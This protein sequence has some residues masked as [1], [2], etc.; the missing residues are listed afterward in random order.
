R[1][2]ACAR[3]SGETEKPMGTDIFS[4]GIRVHLRLDG[5]S[6]SHAG[7]ESG[8]ALGLTRWFKGK[9]WRQALDTLPL[10]FSICSVAQR[11]AAVT[12]VERAAAIGP[13]PHRQSLRELVLDAETAREHLFR[14]FT[15]WSAVLGRQP[16]PKALSSV[17]RLVPEVLASM[18]ADS[19]L[20]LPGTAT[21][22]PDAARL[23]AALN[24]LDSLLREQ[25]LGVDPGNWY[26]MSTVEEFRRW[27]DGSEGLAAQFLRLLDDRHWAE[28]PIPPCEPLPLLD[29]DFLTAALAGD[30]SATFV[31]RP[32]V[33]GR[34]CETGAYVRERHHPLVRAV[35]AHRGTGILMR[36]VARFLELAALPTRMRQRLVELGGLEPATEVR[37][38]GITGVGIGQAEAAR[39]RLVH[40]VVLQDEHVVDYQIVAPTEWNFHPRGVLQQA[41]TGLRRS[42]DLSTLVPLMVTTIDPCVAF[43]L[44]IEEG[45]G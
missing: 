14:L 35:T 12:A 30:E 7:I 43:E 24:R 45:A 21:G 10:V 28:V 38:S 44:D 6:V 11:L 40:R 34:V 41:L 2:F 37:V 42:D 36:L 16:E 31:S 22:A 29:D 23:E 1:T 18:G 33:H 5:E 27:L 13:H 25:V 26:R 3:Q 15:D 17:G 39:G 8:R 19:G 9:P 32:T 20:F 4:G